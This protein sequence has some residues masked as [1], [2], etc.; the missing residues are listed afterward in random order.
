MRPFCGRCLRFEMNYGVAIFDKTGKHA[1]LGPPK[2]EHAMATS[3][4]FYPQNRPLPPSVYKQPSRLTIISPM[5]TPTILNT[6]FVELL[7]PHC[8]VS[9]DV[10]ESTLPITIRRFRFLCISLLFHNWF[11]RILRLLWFERVGIV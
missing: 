6:S 5:L 2:P 1:Y 9:V 3:K 4:S 8:I 7:L 11:Q 10:Y